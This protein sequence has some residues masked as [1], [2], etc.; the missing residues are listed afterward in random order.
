MKTRSP[1][2]GDQLHARPST[3]R[4]RRSRSIIAAAGLRHW[5]APHFVWQVRDELADDPVPATTPDDCDKVDTGGY[6]VTTTLDWDMQ[7]IVES[8]VY[9]AARAPHAKNPRAVLESRKI[10]RKHWAWILGLRGSNIHNAASAVIDYRTGEVL[11]YVG[12]ARYTAKGNEKFQ[13]QFD[14]LSRRL[15]PARVVDQAH[16]LRHRH[17][18]QGLH[19][20]HD[21]HGRDHG[22]RRRVHPDPGGQARARP[23]PAAQRAPVLAQHPGHQG[24]RSSAASSTRSSATQDF[25]LRYHGHGHPGRP[26]WASARS[27]PTR[28]TCSAPTARSPTAACACRARR[29]SEVVDEDGKLVW[30]IGDDE[31]PRASRSSARRPPTSSPTS[32]PATPTPEVNPYWARVGGLRGRQAPPGRLQDRDDERQRRR[33]RL[34]LPR[35]AQGQGG[36]RPWPS[37]SGWAT[38]TTTRTRAACRS[39]RPRRSGRRSLTAVSKDTADRQVQG[40]G[41]AQVG[42]RRRVHRPAPGP[43]TTEDGQGAVPA[44]HR[45]RHGAR[46]HPGQPRDRRGLRPAAGRTAAS[47]PR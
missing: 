25:G 19:R 36:A 45:S 6:R 14:V 13:P 16:Q 12:G 33:P 22:L 1:L 34:R 20:G 4:P 18:G 26:R 9:A 47:G 11:A 46:D 27:R 21:V 28:S 35:A 17:R 30:P 8:Y 44:G 24:R 7:K 2:T 23:G 32:W 3:R 37:A 5:R 31:R 41:R 29:S 38:A 39:T 43:F 10:P 15:A 40:P 42:D